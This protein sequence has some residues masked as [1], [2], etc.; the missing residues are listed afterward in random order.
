MKSFGYYKNSLDSILTNSY[1]DKDE[2]KKNFHVVMGTMKY[3][4]TLREFFH[5]YNEVEQKKF[6][7]TEESHKFINE[8]VSILREKRSELKKVIPILEGVINSRLGLCENTENEIYENLDKLVFFDNT[9]NI[10][11]RIQ[12]K[13]NISKSMVG[14]KSKIVNKSVNPKILSQI[15][16]K[17]YNSEYNNLSESEKDTLKETLYMDKT[18]LI[19]SFSKLSEKTLTEINGLLSEAKDDNLSSKLVEVKNSVRLMSPS[20][21]NYLELK[22]LLSDLN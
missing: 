16:A 17:T 11:E 5:L 15:L 2:F 21:K 6:D 7:S 3:S 14:K 12:L 19:E 22:Q 18:T 13:E 4:R 10:S 1:E 9:K 20:K 8:V